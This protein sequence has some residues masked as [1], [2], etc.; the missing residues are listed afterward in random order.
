MQTCLPQET[1]KSIRHLQQPCKHPACYP[2]RQLPVVT[3]KQ[4]P[5]QKRSISTRFLK[6][7]PFA[8]KRNARAC[9]T[10]QFCAPLQP[11]S[12]SCSTIRCM[13]CCRLL[14]K[15]LP[16]L[17]RAAAKQPLAAARLL[18]QVQLKPPSWGVQVP[19]VGWLQVERQGCE[20]QAQGIWWHACCLE[21]VT[22]LLPSYPWRVKW[23]VPL[24]WEYVQQ[25]GA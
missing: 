2:V 6:A 22:L 4:R 9:C 15:L 11:F 10:K 7:S 19:C 13:R 5:A 14:L 21:Q 24:S 12:S 25:S 1:A 8:V 17:L 18:Q 16:L 20:L 23:A 3:G